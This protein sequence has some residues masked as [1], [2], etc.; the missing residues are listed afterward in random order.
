[1][2]SIR[3]I[4]VQSAVIQA[5]MPEAQKLQNSF[6]DRQELRIKDLRHLRKSEI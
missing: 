4:F 1:M 3:L 5:L 6:L 2:Q